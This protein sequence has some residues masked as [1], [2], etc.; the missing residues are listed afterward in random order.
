MGYGTSEDCNTGYPRHLKYEVN[1]GGM[2]GHGLERR[3]FSV[4]LGNGDS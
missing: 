2:P 4:R 1:A 3:K